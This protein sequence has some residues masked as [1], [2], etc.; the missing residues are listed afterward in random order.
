M[1][2][3]VL[4]HWL[5]ARRN[6]KYVHQSLFFLSFLLK[7]LQNGFKIEIKM[8]LLVLDAIQPLLIAVEENMTVLSDTP[9]KLQIDT[10]SVVFLILECHVYLKD[11][12]S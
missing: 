2:V 5:S 7:T 10:V 9:E 11:Y 4:A 1:H 8:S 3:E 6:T 12:I